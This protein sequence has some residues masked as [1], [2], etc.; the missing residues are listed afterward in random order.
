MGHTGVNGPRRRPGKGVQPLAEF[1]TRHL[2]LSLSLLS[3]EQ[4]NIW[5]VH[6]IVGSCQAEETAAINFQSV[7]SR[8]VHFA[9]RRDVIEWESYTLVLTWSLSETRRLRQK[10]DWPLTKKSS[11][12]TKRHMWNLG[13]I[14]VRSGNLE[15]FWSNR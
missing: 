3:K 4:T 13:W 7:L 6:A 5:E 14:T 8:R 2:I 15:I 12:G 10:T 1:A 9:I 11:D